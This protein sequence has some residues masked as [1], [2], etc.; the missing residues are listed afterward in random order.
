MCR[1]RVHFP[2]GRVPAPY[3]QVVITRGQCTGGNSQDHQ[4]PRAVVEVQQWVSFY[5]RFTFGAS[6]NNTTL[7]LKR[8]EG[9]KRSP[10][11]GLPWNF[12]ALFSRTPPLSNPGNYTWG[13]TFRHGL[14]SGVTART[15]RF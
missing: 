13:W 12:L 8:V 1:D 15:L 6:G 7:T 10:L 4:L 9:R 14:K 5:L 3:P 11:S 2:L